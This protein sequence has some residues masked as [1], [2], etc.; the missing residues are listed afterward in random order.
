MKGD[1]LM[2]NIKNVA[3][4]AGVSVTTVS[5][6]LNSRGYISKETRRKVEEAMAELNYSPN[7]IARALQKSQSHIL[8]MIVPDL[9]HPFF[10]ELIKHVE[11][12]ANEKQY[13]ILICNSL[14]QSEKEANYIS[15]LSENRVD[16][17]IMCS[18]TLDVEAYKKLHL[19]IVTFDRIISNQFPYVASDNFRGGEIATEH[20]I[21]AGCKRLL[22]ISG[23][24][25]LDL[26]ANRRAD[27]FKLI[28]LKHNLPYTIIEGLNS[29]LTFEY[30][31]DFIE[32]EVAG[33]LSNFDGVFCSNDIVA[34]ALYLYAMENGINVP[35]QLKIIGYD[36]HS[37]TRMLKTPQ[38]TTIAQP[39]KRLGKVLSSTIIDMIENKDKD[40]IN[41]TVVD[42]E[43]MKGQTT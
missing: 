24:L 20:L 13:K 41:N 8:G 32:N 25:N 29:N 19:P 2:A 10:S 5:R 35:E 40:T 9:N 16:G 33:S 26:L 31:T 28:C 12:S 15:M 27:A 43:L 18:H 34:Y 36:Y 1:L 30:F 4:R 7:Q 17:I 39:I 38:L 21:A 42:V 37:F 14:D 6:V 3:I 11:M 22:H 23:P